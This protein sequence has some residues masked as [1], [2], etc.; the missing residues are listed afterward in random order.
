MTF[1]IIFIQ[2]ILIEVCLEKSRSAISNENGA[3]YRFAYDVLDRLIAE[4]GQQT[5]YFHCDQIGIPR[6]MTDKDGN[7]L[8]FGNYTG[9]GRL[10]EETK[11]TDSA[12]QPF[13][14]QNQ[15]C[16][17]ETGLH[18]NFFRYYE[19][20]A[21]RFMNQD[22]IGLFCGENL[23][24]F[25]SNSQMWIDPLGLN[26]FNRITGQTVQRATDLSILRPG[27]QGWKDALT[28][29]QKERRRINL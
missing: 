25:A 16:D 3:R 1:P 20:D 5:Y 23:Y 17:E 21:G 10:K 26:P 14:L 18:Y 2:K 29:L 27:M 11:V 12:Y 22:P 19:P 13:R 7:L 15:Y 24:Q 28:A 9:W 6:E 4:S 8:W